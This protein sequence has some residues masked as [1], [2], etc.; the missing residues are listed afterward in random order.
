MFKLLAK[1]SKVVKVVLGS[2]FLVLGSWFLVLGSWF[3]VLGSW[4]LVFSWRYWQW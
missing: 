4:F 3:L 2:W 1:A